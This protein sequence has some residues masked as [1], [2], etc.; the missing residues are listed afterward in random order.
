M[1]RHQLSRH[2]EAAAG[3]QTQRLLDGAMGAIELQGGARLRYDQTNVLSAP[4]ADNPIWCVWVIRSAVCGPGGD[5]MHDE[6]PLRRKGR[7]PAVRQRDGLR[8]GQLHR[9]DVHGRAHL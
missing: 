5:E 3:V 8:G 2:V 1:L 9:V 7:L 6:R 4:L